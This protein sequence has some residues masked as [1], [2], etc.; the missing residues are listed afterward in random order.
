MSDN[1][2]AQSD[3]APLLVWLR[4]QNDLR[5]QR[6]KEGAS[7]TAGENRPVR[8]SRMTIVGSFL[9]A[10]FYPVLLVIYLLVEV[11]VSMLAYM[12][13]NLYHIETFGYLIGLS[14]VLLNQFADHLEKLSPE[15][16]NQAYATILGELGAKSIL[17]LFIGLAAN[18]AI[19]FLIWFVHKGVETARPAKA[20][21]T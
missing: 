3:V 21:Q 12:Y 15:I 14:R 6:R 4:L 16:A 1:G 19:R 11:L 17:L 7:E 5:K 20:Q 8:H 2:K 18:A 10:I 9:K 13:L